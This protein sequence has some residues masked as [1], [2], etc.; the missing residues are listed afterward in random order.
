MSAVLANQI[1]SMAHR[2]TAGAHKCLPGFCTPDGVEEEVFSARHFSCF[3]SS[4]LNIWQYVL[5]VL[6]SNPDCTVHPTV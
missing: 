2:L 3:L 1:L 6:S 5:E 4:S